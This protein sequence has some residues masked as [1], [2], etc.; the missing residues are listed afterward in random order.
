MS[1]VLGVFGQIGSGKSTV[2]KILER[3][4][5]YYSIDCDALGHRLYEDKAIKNE[6]IHLFGLQILAKDNKIDR[7]KLSQVVF[8]N[9]A[10]KN[11]LEQLLWPKMTYQLKFIIEEETTIVI[12][13]AVLFLAGWNQLCQITVYVEAPEENLANYWKDRNIEKANLKRILDSQQVIIQQKSLATYVIHNDG[14]LQDLQRK[15]SD[16]IKLIENSG[17]KNKQPK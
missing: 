11:Q 3:D 10:L 5:G 6:I 16:M 4:F 12:D 9:H 13:A 1:F 17:A 15:V 14:T 8:T 7:K 2:T